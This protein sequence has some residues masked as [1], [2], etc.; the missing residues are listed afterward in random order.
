VL[1]SHSLDGSEVKAWYGE[2][3]ARY[4]ELT[5][6]VKF[7]HAIPKNP[8]GMILKRVLMDMAKRETEQGKAKL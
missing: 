4:K 3:L 2:R 5:G 7:V 1:E 6:V 8:S